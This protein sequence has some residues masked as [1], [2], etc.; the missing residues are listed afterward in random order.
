MLEPIRIKDLL[1]VF[2][3][4]DDDRQVDE[5]IITGALKEA[6]AKAY[7]RQIDAPDAVV[8]VEIDD[9]YLRMYHDLLVVEE[10]SGYEELE[11][12]LAEAKKINENIKIGEYIANEIDIKSLNRSSVLHVKSIIKQK[13]R[14]AEKQLIFEEFI[15]SKGEL[16]IGNITSVEENAIHIKIGKGYAVLPRSQQIPGEIHYPG[17]KIRVLISDVKKETKG[18]QIIASRSDATFVK[19]LFER[20]VP[21]IFQG[22]VEIKAIARDAGERTKMAVY[23][24]DD[25]IDPI[26]ACIGPRGSRIQAIIS[27]IKGEKIDVFQWSDNEME[28]I[29]NAF[30][31]ANIIGCYYGEDQREIIVVVD[32]NQLSLAIGKKGKNV[33]LATKLINCKIDI[34]TMPDVMELGIDFETKVNEFNE[35]QA[36]KRRLKE[37]KAFRELQAEMARKLEALEAVEAENPF[38]AFEDEELI[39]DLEAHQELENNNDELETTNQDQEVLEEDEVE[40]EPLILRPRSEKVETKNVYVSKFEE[41]ADASSIIKR[42]EETKKKRRKKDDEDRKLRPNEINRDKDYDF[43]VEY[44]ED[45]LEEIEA[46]QEEEQANSWIE[47]DDIDFDEYDEYYDEDIK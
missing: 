19:R 37:E 16:M 41:L 3:D 32:E 8:R 4:V 27:E 7:I 47:D 29:K 5:E 25:N 36:E 45:E 33:K 46:M 21:E 38:E 22:S 35:I 15:D 14:E 17:E 39:E 43:K 26:G 23:S 40:L 1:A 28:L 9:T 30:A 42:K 34:K 2:K 12:S 31:P 13:I 6:F 20:E 44:S 11:I 18:A 24:K 10:D